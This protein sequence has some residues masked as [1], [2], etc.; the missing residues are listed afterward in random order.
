MEALDLFSGLGG[1]AY[2]FDRAGISPKAFCEIKPYCRSILNQLWPDKIIYEDIK[3]LTAERLEKDGILPVDIIYG[4]DPCQRNSNA[5]RHGGGEPSP[6]N[7]FIRLVKECRPP[8]VLR[9]N[10]SRVRKDA[11]WP[12]W[13]FRNELEALDYGVLPF[14]L[15]ACCVGADHQRERLFLLAA[16]PDSDCEGLER[17]V[18]KILEDSI[19][20][21]QDADLARPD[22]WSATP[23]V[24]GSVDRIPNKRDRIEG[25]GNM[26]CPACAELIGRLIK[27][28]FVKEPMK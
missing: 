11:P 3:T 24:C 6:A 25:I 27:N 9:E 28:Y 19:Q 2:G 26:V 20:G 1:M 8:V 4:G 17:N 13:R 14:R 22:R 15:R 12:W 18:S 10:P 21:G 7:H 16:L 5:W 23:R